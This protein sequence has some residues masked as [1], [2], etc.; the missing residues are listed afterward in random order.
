MA[1]EDA[2]FGSLHDA[3]VVPTKNYRRIRNAKNLLA[4]TLSLAVMGGLLVIGLVVFGNPSSTSA[5]NGG[6]PTLV[7]ALRGTSTVEG[8]TLQDFGDGE[9]EVAALCFP[10]LDLVD[11]KTGKV[12]GSAEDCVRVDSGDPADPTMSAVVLGT[13]FF[14]FH[15]GGGKGSQ[16]VSRGVTTLQPLLVTD[17]DITHITGAIPAPGSNQVVHGTRRFEGA[18]GTVRLSGAVDTSLLGSAGIITFD[19]IF[20]INLQ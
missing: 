16:L 13:T 20:E 14:N 3:A 9:G 15:D 5:N 7:V 2:Q 4:T 6:D 10:G 1:A 18:E 12:I 17:S 8:K 11:V 19:C